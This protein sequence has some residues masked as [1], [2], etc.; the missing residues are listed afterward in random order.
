MKEL[1]KM[2][3]SIK[4]ELTALHEAN[5]TDEERERREANGE[6]C[7]LYDYFSD[8]LDV[9]YTV[10]SRG[11]YLGASLWVTLGGPNIWIDTRRQNI[12]GAWGSDRAE[13]WLPSEVCS[14]IDEIFEESYNLLK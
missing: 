3:K 4:E 9:E 11:D 7:D 14:A 12:M 1:V 8:V 2:L 6:P 13:F 10:S 5:F